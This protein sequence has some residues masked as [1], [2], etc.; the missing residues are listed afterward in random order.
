MPAYFTCLLG[1]EL[2]SI[3]PKSVDVFGDTGGHLA[4]SLLARSPMS[5]TA[6]ILPL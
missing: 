1:E 6:V 4:A 2:I 5:G 3:P